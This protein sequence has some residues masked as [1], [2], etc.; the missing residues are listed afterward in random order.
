MTGEILRDRLGV[1]HVTVAHH[2][3][4]DLLDR[5]FEELGSFDC[6]FTAGRI[7]LY[8]HHDDR[9]WTPVRDF[10]LGAGR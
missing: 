2:L 8:E 5:A 9:G 3:P 10:L 1:P 7:S 4:D 6:R